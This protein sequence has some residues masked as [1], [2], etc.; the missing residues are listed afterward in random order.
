MLA[1]LGDFFMQ[2]FLARCRQAKNGGFGY[3]RFLYKLA[4][5]TVENIKYNR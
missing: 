4:M 5:L 3:L 2:M 1:A